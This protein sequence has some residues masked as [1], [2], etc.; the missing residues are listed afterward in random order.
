MRRLFISVLAALLVGMLLVQAMN[1]DP[2]YLL[3]AWG[4]YTLEMSVWTGIALFVAVFTSLYFLVRLWR[5]TWRT[6]RRVRNWLENRSLR[7]SHNRTTKGLIAFIEGHWADARTTLVKVA[8]RSDSP[9][10]FYLMAARASHE[11]DE[12][13]ELEYYL[14]RAEES[15]SGA[16]IAVGLTQAEMQLS[17]GKLEQCLATLNRV[18]AVSTD[19]PVALTM[20]VK[21]YQGLQ[22]WPELRELLPTLKKVGI[23]KTDTLLAIEAETHSHI[24]SAGKPELDK[25][26]EDAWQQ[27]PKTLRNNPVILSAYCQQLVARGEFDSAEKLLRKSLRKQWDE[28]LADLYGQVNGPAPAKQLQ[29]AEEWLGEHS[30]NPVLLLTLGRLC[31]ANQLWGKARE[32]FEASLRA[33]ECPEVCAELGRLSAHLGEQQASAEYFKRGLLSVSKPLPELPLP[34]LPTA[35]NSSPMIR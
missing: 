22:A 31:L 24:L 10:L 4:D 32:Y 2:G 9:L 27:V 6:K 34:A 16:D 20:L 14:K 5:R 28:S 19:H 3:I 21:V 11:L 33:Q 35:A 29:Y 26:L 30:N 15:T 12:P 1:S 17:N 8:E 25:T 23:F 13:K 7:I 18:R